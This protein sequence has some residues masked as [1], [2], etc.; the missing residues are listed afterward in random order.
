MFLSW[1]KY[2]KSD[3]GMTLNGALAGL[4]SITAGT[5]SVSPLSAVIIGG[6][7]GI[8]VLFAVEFIDKK[9]KIDDPVGA[10]SVHG[11]CGAFGTLMVGLFAQ[12]AFGGVNGLLFGGGIRLLIVQAIGVLAVF[13]WVF[14]TSFV[15]FKLIDWVIGLRVSREEELMG[16]DISEHGAEAYADFPISASSN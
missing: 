13:A 9:L 10:I 6:L 8:L 16:L 12:E 2:G 5:A 1:F 14:T 3:I 15:L 11:V 7:G 4:V